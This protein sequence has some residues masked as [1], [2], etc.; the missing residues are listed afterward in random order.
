MLA[1]TQISCF[2]KKMAIGKYQAVLNTNSVTWISGEQSVSIKSSTEIASVMLLRRDLQHGCQKVC[3]IT[4][5]SSF[6]EYKA[7]YLAPLAF[8][9]SNLCVCERECVDG[10]RGGVG[11]G[12]TRTRC[13]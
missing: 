13:M 1:S 6:T 3:Y 9:L 10:E 7:A 11:G 12:N 5:K 8:S 4:L 2:Y